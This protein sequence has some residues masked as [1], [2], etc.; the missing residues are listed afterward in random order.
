MG[1]ISDAIQRIPFFVDKSGD[2]LK[3]Q[4]NKTH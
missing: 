4:V 1:A 2:A 3:K